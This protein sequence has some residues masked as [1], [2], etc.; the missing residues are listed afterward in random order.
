MFMDRPSP[1]CRILKGVRFCIFILPA[2]ILC[3]QM[4]EDLTRDFSS[5]TRVR[6]IVSVHKFMQS[7]ASHC[8]QFVAN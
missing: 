7:A 8:F 5:R 6:N 2:L 1:T 3:L 4:E